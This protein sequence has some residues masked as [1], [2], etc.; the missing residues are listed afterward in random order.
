MFAGGSLWTEG[1]ETRLEQTEKLSLTLFM[2]LS[3]DSAFA[4]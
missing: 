4:V 3:Y 2:T 1:S